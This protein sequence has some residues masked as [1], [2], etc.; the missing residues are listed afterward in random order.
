MADVSSNVP[1]VLV[2]DPDP[3]QQQR[4]AQMLY[5]RFRVI[6]AGSI[7]EAVQQI[8]TNNPPIALI[9]VDLPDGDG[10]TLIKQIRENPR[11]QRMIVACVTH[12]SAIREKVAGFHAGAD[13]YII[14]PVNPETFVWR[15][16][17]LTKMR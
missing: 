12:R 1:L 3:V 17:L 8:M 16:V 13:D 7:A 6:G 5:P 11:T 9:E 4:L 10:K 2:V 15:V 14:K